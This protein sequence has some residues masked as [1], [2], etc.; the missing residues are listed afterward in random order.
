MDARQ[1]IWNKTYIHQMRRFL[2]IAFILFLTSCSDHLAD[3]PVVYTD[4]IV[5]GFSVRYDANME[6]AHKELMF[7]ILNSMVF[8]EGDCFLM[9]ENSERAADGP[10]HYVRVSDYYI[11]NMELSYKDLR[12]LSVYSYLSWYEWQSFIEILKEMTGLD[13]D[14]PTEAQWEFAAKGGKYSKGYTYAGSDNIDEVRCDTYPCERDCVANELGLMNMSGGLSE[15]CKDFYKPYEPFYSVDPC[16]R[17]GQ[18]AVVRGGSYESYK[19]NS[20]FNTD[21]SDFFCEDDYRMC[22]TT[23]RMYKAPDEIGITIGCRL[24]INI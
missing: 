16:V 4:E 17:G 15:W 7:R 8:V 10:A 5:N 6:P 18:Y 11:S 2:Y 24:V 13:F 20:K 22:K 1:R 14:L 21:P 19:E 9:G 12:V 3:K 23:S